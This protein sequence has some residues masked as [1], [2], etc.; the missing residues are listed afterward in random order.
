MIKPQV[1]NQTKNEVVKSE[2]SNLPN[3]H[4][5]INLLPLEIILSRKQHSKLSL[6]SKISVASLVVLI[7]FTSTTLALRFSQTFELK[8]SEQGLVLAESKVSNLKDQEGQAVALKQRLIA[9][10]AILGGDAKRK[11]IFNMV[12]YLI[13]ADLQVMEVNVDKNGNMNLVLSSASL[14]SIQTLINNLGDKEKNSDLISKVDLDGMSL[15]RDSVYNFS[16]RVV[17]K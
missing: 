17:P 6:I 10:D 13:P 9:I 11:S 12:I 5:M 3:N 2:V 14:T 4:L 7:F 8:K 1:S 16:L 15:G